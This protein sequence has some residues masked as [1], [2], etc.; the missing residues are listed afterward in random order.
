MSDRDGNAER[1]Q[2]IE[3]AL[4]SIGPR[5]TPSEAGTK[6]AYARAH[7][8]WRE[9]VRHRS[10]RLRRRRGVAALLAASVLIASL[11]ALFPLLRTPAPAAVVA[12]ALGTTHRVEQ[13]GSSSLLHEQDALPIGAIIETAADARIALRLSTGHSLRLDR[14]TRLAIVGRSD[15][16]LERGRAYV[17]SDSAQQDAF[18]RIRTPLASVSEIGTQFQVEW[19]ADTLRVRVREGSVELAAGAASS[20]ADIVVAGEAAML[21]QG[22]ELER[23]ADSPFGAE[24]AWVAEVSPGLDP[25]ERGLEQVLN[26]VCREL[27]CRL[28]YANDDTHALAQRIELAGSLDGLTPEQ[29]L[30]VLEKITAFRYRRANGELTLEFME[31]TPDEQ[32]L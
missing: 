32:K 4:H 5:P 1:T 12:R 9:L 20:A 28:R 18:V 11:A 19:F 14:A 25:D 3:S 23:T 17:D 30:D 6:R 22:R 2:L 27:G 24:W 13:Q 8:Q 15:F 16:R 31:E 26:W 10:R 7:E 21:A 29:T